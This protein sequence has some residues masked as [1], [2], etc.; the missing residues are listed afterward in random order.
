MAQV[1]TPVENTDTY[2]WSQA[3]V[4]RIFSVCGDLC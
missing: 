1:Y 4:G 2:R 3:N